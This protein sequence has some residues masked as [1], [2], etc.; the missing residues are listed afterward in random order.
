MFHLCKKQNKTVSLYK[1]KQRKKTTKFKLYYLGQW[2]LEGTKL[3]TRTGISLTGN[4]KIPSVG[5]LGVIK[6]TDTGMDV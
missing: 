3:S 5:T 4:W 2:K 1:K 6:N